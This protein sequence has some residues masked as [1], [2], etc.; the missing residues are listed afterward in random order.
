MRVWLSL[1]LLLAAGAPAAAQTVTAR[2]G[3]TGTGTAPAQESKAVLVLHSYGYDTPGRLLFDA[4]LARTMRE[5]ADANIDLYV[6]TI[7]PNRFR[8]EAQLHRTRSFLRERYADK[9]IAV[10]V[11]VYERALGISARHGRSA[12]C[13]DPGRRV[14]AGEST[15]ASRTR[16]GGLVGPDVRPN[17]GNGASAA[18]RHAADRADRRGA[19]GEAW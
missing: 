17:G 2:P 4:A 11:A 5:A 3:T 16:L 7:D 12:V 18:S 19:P 9:R 15:H 10:V 14:A 1:V 8:G 13:R 6:E